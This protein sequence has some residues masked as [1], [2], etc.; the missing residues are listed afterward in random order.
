MSREPGRPLAGDP[1]IRE[2][3]PD[4]AP[5]LRE[6]AIRTY[7]EAFGASFSPPDLAAVL[8]ASFAPEAV[9]RWIAEDRVLLAAVGG[10]MVGFGQLGETRDGGLSLRRLYVEADLRGRGLGTALLARLLEGVTD[11]EVRLDVWEFNPGARRLYERFGFRVSGETRMA[12]ASGGEGD[13]DW[14]MTRPPRTV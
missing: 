2:A 11:R 3:V 14:I 13:R 5:T 8:A 1:T 7:A 9:D 4:D 12:L 6:L 10:R